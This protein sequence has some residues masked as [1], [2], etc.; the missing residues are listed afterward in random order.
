MSTADHS[1][2]SEIYRA[3][4]NNQELHEDG[5]YIIV[6]AGCSKCLKAFKVK[7]KRSDVEHYSYTCPNCGRV[8]TAT[9]ENPVDAETST[10]SR[11]Q[12]AISMSIYGMLL[13]KLIKYALGFSFPAIFMII[14]DIGM[15]FYVFTKKPKVGVGTKVLAIL[16]FLVSVELL[17]RTLF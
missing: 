3:D 16:F 5:D 4:S 1:S 7:I 9:N 10:N 14:Y 12:I 2:N 8:T 17:R 15:V 13:A 6:P 11:A